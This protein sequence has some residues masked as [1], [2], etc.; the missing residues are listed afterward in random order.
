VKKTK[1]SADDDDSIDICGG[2]TDDNVK[3][4]C[5]NNDRVLDNE[6]NSSDDESLHAWVMELRR[7]DTPPLVHVLDDDDILDD[8]W[9]RIDEDYIPIIDRNGKTIGM[10]YCLKN[11]K[12]STQDGRPMRYTWENFMDQFKSDDEHYLV[13]DKTGKMISL[14][15]VSNKMGGVAHDAAVAKEHKRTMKA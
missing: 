4:E 7:M 15:T 3:E 1:T 6:S 8:F 12:V 9:E 11:G 13:D 14:D 2:G 5:D 10:K